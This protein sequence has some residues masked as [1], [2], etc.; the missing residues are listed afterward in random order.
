[1]KS[2][3]E[4]T[5]EQHL[6]SM[7]DPKELSHTIGVALIADQEIQ[8]LQ[9]YANEVSIK[10]LGYNDH[11]PVHMRQV[12]INSLVMLKILHES[13]VKTSLEKEEGGTF[14]DSV[15]GVLL[16]SFL[17]DLGMTVSRTDHETMSC[18]IA[19]PIMQR[20]L[21]G[22]I[23][24]NPQEKI[25]ILSIATE[26]ILGHMAS[27]KIHSVEAGLI[28][29]ADGCD[30]EKGRARIPL[31]LNTEAKVGDIHKYSSK[32]IER[33][34]IGKG[35][36]HPIKIEVEMSSDVGFFQ[37]EEVLLQKIA[38]SPDKGLVEVYAWV[39]GQPK[40]QYL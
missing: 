15:C 20:I 9:E 19:R 2:P 12:A 17:H 8:Y 23:P 38:M 26:G 1:M 5:L 37:I 29:I 27:K 18:M 39:T 6:M 33:V 30:M 4:I 10:R 34:T 22:L 40:K 32:A 35:E 24:S 7:L 13:G 36:S 11:G 3:K 14:D 25:A 16:A 28:L 31:I 21:D